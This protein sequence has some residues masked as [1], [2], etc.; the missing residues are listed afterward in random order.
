MSKGPAGRWQWEPDHEKWQVPTQSSA[1]AGVRSWGASEEQ[2]MGSEGGVCLDKPAGRLH[3]GP[4]G[5][6]A[7]AGRSHVVLKAPVTL[8]FRKSSARSQP[9]GSAGPRCIQL[10]TSSVTCG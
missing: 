7:G 5:T 9:Q 6:G 4:K 3:L 8:P 1:Q 2:G 10:S